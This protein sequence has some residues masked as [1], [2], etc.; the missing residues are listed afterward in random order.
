MNR[1][2][3]FAQSIRDVASGKITHTQKSRSNEQRR[4]DPL[5]TKVQPLAEKDPLSK[6]IVT[7]FKRVRKSQ[8]ER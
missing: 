1:D 2:T 3:A 5:T 4:L 7:G 6:F 8:S